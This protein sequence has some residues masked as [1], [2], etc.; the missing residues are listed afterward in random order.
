MSLDFK[1]IDAEDFLE[2]VLDGRRSCAE[3]PTFYNY[4][5]KRFFKNEDDIP[6]GW[7]EK[8]VQLK[9]NKF[10]EVLRMKG[11]GL[12]D[13]PK[14]HKPSTYMAVLEEAGLL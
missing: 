10:N 5:T 3:W 13:Y 8:Y 11:K 12:I 4:V 6:Y 1:G 9:I 14:K 2:A 7:N